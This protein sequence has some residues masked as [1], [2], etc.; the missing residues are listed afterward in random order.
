MKKKVYLCAL[1]KKN[2]T[3]AFVGNSPHFFNATDRQDSQHENCQKTSDS[4]GK[5]N[6]VCP[7]HCF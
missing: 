5:L 3:T 2:K 7:Y 1:L 4:H 6:S